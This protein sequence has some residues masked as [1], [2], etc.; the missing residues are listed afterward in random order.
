MKAALSPRGRIV[1]PRAVKKLRPARDRKPLTQVYRRTGAGDS[2]D[3]GM[4]DSFSQLR[5]CSEF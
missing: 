4:Q 3:G 5:L 2:G 1:S